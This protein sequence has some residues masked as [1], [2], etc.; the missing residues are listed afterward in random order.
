MPLDIF[1]QV[2]LNGVLLGGIYALVAFGLSLVYGVAHILNIA[3]GTLLAI[4]GVVASLIF[5]KT[6]WNPV[7]IIPMIVIPVFAFG[8]L[9]HAGLLRPLAL[10][11]A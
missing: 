10:L 2:L 7:L 3:H 8:Y 1:I 6:G 5:L 11:L 9:F 4:S